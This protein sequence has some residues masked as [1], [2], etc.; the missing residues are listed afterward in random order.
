MLL[1]FA[2][3]F[4]SVYNA[5]MNTFRVTYDGPALDTHEMDARELAPAL[6]AIS[7]L[8]EASNRV[9]NDNRA[10]VSVRVRGS[11]KSGSFGIDFAV[12]QKLSA[13]LVELFSG[14]NAT[15]IAN[16]VAIAGLLWGGGRGLVATLKWVRGRKITKVIEHEG[17]AKLYVDEDFLE[18]ELA[19]LALLRD[20]E[21]RRALEA[22]TKP[23]D[24]DG[25]DTLA[26]G[27]DGEVQE[28]V[29]KSEAPWFAVPM[30]DDEPL[31]EA[32][33]EATLQIARIEFN[34][35]N[36]WRF[37]DGEASFYAAILDD[38]FLNRINKN[39]EVFSKG[40]ILRARIKKRQWLSGEKM[41]TEYF[42]LHVI[43]H[44]GGA[45]QIRLPLS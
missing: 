23:L 25:I 33:Y 34:E 6:M 39:E 29:L 26:F 30:T 38:D 9:L 5:S 31:D 35:D 41:R 27:T 12:A 15:A 4:I 40:D 8:L 18:V 21:L 10:E 7:D 36:K 45:R 32:E 1:F 24:R 14:Q 19:V 11:F 44:H 42:V 17:H 3:K 43:S 20:Y 2:F 37:T 16:A 13:Q 28:T 22:A